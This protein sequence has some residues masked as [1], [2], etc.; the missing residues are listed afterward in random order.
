MEYFRKRIYLFYFLLIFAINFFIYKDVF[1]Q[2][3]IIFPS[4]FL[5]QFYSPWSTVKFTGW[6]LGIPHKPTGSDII[7]SFYPDRTL[8]NDALNNSRLPLWNPYAFSGFPLLANLQSAVFYPL[9]FIYF[10]FP[11]I[12]S[13]SILIFTQ[14]ILAMIFTYLY[15]RSLNLG[16]ISSILGAFTFAFSNTF[17][18]WSYENP[19]VSRTILWL[20]LVLYGMES[21]IKNNK[22]RYYFLSI[23]ALTTSFLAG[24]LQITFY[25]YI[26]SF[27]YWLVRIRKLSNKKLN[28]LFLIFAY[29]FSLALSAIQLLPSLEA[30]M[31]SPRAFSQA[32]YLFDIYLLPITHLLNVLIPDI[33]G[34]SG[35]YNFFGRG[36]YHETVIS[37]GIIS[38]IFALFAI[39]G[40]KKK[41][42]IAFFTISSLLSFFLTIKSPITDFFYNLPLPLIPTFLPSRIFFISAFSFS[43]LSAFGIEEFIKGKNKN[44]K[45]C[46]LI[47]FL[48]FLL[49]GLV[50][51][52][53]FLINKINS[54][55]LK[56]FSNYIIKPSYSFQQGHL[57][58]I[59]KNTFLSLLLIALIFFIKKIRIKKNIL[60]FVLA[61]FIFFSQFYYLK[62]QIVLGFPQFLYPAHPIFSFLK[63]NDFPP[64]RFIVFKKPILGNIWEQEK[65]YSPEGMDPFYPQR[66]GQIVFASKNNGKLAINNLPR[67]EVTLSEIQEN[68]TILENKRRLKLLSLLGVKYFVYY[69]DLNSILSSDQI[70]PNDNFPILFKND[71]WYIFKNNFSLPRVYFVDNYL[72]EKNPQKILD[73][74]FDK[75]FDIA[76]KLILEEKP[77]FPQSTL[78]NNSNLISSTT[79]TEYTPEEIK[80]IVINNKNSL[81]FLSD[82]FYPGW[83]AYING[84]STKIYRANYTFRALPISK[85]Q[86]EIVFKY[87]PLSFFVGAAI[88]VS[89]IFLMLVIFL[90]LRY[91]KITRYKF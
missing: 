3:K 10:V 19:T 73:T 29:V 50:L 65:I 28:L 24:F 40:Y 78:K 30:F 23:F 6:E 88:S 52:Y 45:A 84:V 86:H 53:V 68:E 32:T 16:K 8:I 63:E 38:L 17:T 85:G 1:L 27:L 57:I 5:A 11:Q 37:I 7:R 2:G 59:L 64:D 9:N 74:F 31:N 44:E 69:N 35:S 67:I 60:I 42:Y 43:V 83:K 18:I 62:K 14:S 82:N 91:K 26:F 81:L 47:F 56:N 66:Y 15:L 48:I 33:F 75:N 36:A 39:V 79:I 22:F 61:I 12:I 4:N 76:N 80:I 90:Y 89:S 70:F 20:P 46:N 71:R 77:I 72:I 49:L 54:E 13:W 55:I 51:L 25:I 87:Q 21:F 58:I 34:S 41:S